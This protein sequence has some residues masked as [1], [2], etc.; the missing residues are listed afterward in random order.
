MANQQCENYVLYDWCGT[1]IKY[2]FMINYESKKK[3]IRQQVT[4]LI[5]WKRGMTWFYI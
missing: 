5:F 2:I 1:I 4:G 3:K